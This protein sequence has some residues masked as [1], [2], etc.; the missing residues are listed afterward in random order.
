MNS[1]RNASVSDLRMQRVLHVDYIVTREPR[2]DYV[3]VVVVIQ[4]L[5][6]IDPAA[7]G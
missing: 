6:K 5:S 4:S 3:V 2:S 1:F 7:R